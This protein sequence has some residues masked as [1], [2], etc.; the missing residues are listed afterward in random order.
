MHACIHTCYS[1][2]KDCTHTHTQHT[3]TH[4]HIYIYIYNTLVAPGPVLCVG[5]AVV[6]IANGNTIIATSI[7]HVT[8][9]LSLPHCNPR[10]TA[11]ILAIINFLYTPDPSLADALSDDGDGHGGEGEEASQTSS[12]K[13]AKLDTH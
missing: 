13:Q 12:S 7:I 9:S 5:C 10:R 6:T 8:Q 3:H 4:T 1:L 11:Q 2:I